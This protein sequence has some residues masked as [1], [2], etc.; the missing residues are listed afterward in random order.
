MIIDP[1]TIK[2]IK[3]YKMLKILWLH[4]ISGV[5]VVDEDGILLGI[6]TN[7]D[8]RFTKDYSKLVEEK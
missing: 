2:R 1:V 4:K 3:H 6:L 5:P 7:R 8:M